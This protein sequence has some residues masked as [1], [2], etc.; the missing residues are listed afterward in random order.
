MS[1]SSLFSCM[2]RGVSCVLAV[3][4]ESAE[5]NVNRFRCQKDEKEMLKW[6]VRNKLETF[7]D[8]SLH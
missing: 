4:S 3:V 7:E 8:E 6:K 1:V 2:D 5:S